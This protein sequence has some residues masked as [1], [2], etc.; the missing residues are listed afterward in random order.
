MNPFIPESLPIVGIDWESLVRKIGSANAEIARYDGLLQSLPNPNV[1]LSPLTTNEAVLSSKIEGTQA[2]LEEVFE[3][4]AGIGKQSSSN[5]QDDIKEII[6]YRSVLLSAEKELKSKPISLHLI[7]GL[8]EVLL[9][10]VRGKDKTPGKFRTDQ[11]W[12]GKLGTSMAGARYIP[13]NPMIL[14]EHL[15][16]WVKFIQMKNYP[17][18]IVQLAI[19]HA[20]FEIIHPFKD[21]N[22]R[23]GRLL[24]PLFLYHKKC[25]IRPMFYLSEYLESHREE[26]YDR[27]LAITEEGD[28]FGWIEYFLN[29]I[30]V[31]AKKNIGKAKKIQ[32]L[33]EHLKSSF[34]NST[35]S[36]YAIPA[37]DAFFHSPILSSTAFAASS[38]IKTRA[39]S[40]H[41]LEKLSSQKLL[42]LIREAKGSKPAVYALSELI[43]IADEK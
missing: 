38:G 27:L 40:N 30:I 33:Y 32:N 10:S 25:L 34:I 5:V 22:G 12:I 28:W 8:H 16:N 9:D 31:Q 39:T 14:Q 21:G 19:I 36:Q 23:I 18:A 35:H 1:L 7:K 4:D 26:Y 2:S 15:E 37:L 6:N 29:A 17:D 11:N 43:I 3:A 42:Y 13:P 20:Q 41:I 24:I